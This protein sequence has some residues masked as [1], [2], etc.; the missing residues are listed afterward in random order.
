MHYWLF[1]QPR[2]GLTACHSL[3]VEHSPHSE[4]SLVKLWETV[5]FM[6]AQV[7]QKQWLSKTVRAKGLQTRSIGPTRSLW[8]KQSRKAAPLLARWMSPCPPSS[9]GRNNTL[10]GTQWRRSQKKSTNTACIL[11]SSCTGGYTH[12]KRCHNIDDARLLITSVRPLKDMCGKIHFHFLRRPSTFFKTLSQFLHTKESLPRYTPIYFKPP[13]FFINPA[14]KTSSCLTHHQL[15][16]L[17]F[18]SS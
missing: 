11:V 13:L 5:Q 8:M 14:G 7:H 3:F 18:S 9:F 4:Q 6:S 15:S 2:Q 12:D 16:Q 17:H 1:Q 10:C